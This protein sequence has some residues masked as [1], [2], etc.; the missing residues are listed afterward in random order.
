MF[1]FAASYGMEL[2]GEVPIEL[3]SEHQCSKTTKLASKERGLH[4]SKDKH[5][6]V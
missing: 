3:S 5:W 4:D 6:K 1:P 2:G